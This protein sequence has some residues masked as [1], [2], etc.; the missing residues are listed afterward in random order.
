MRKAFEYAGIDTCAADGLCSI[1]CPVSIDTGNLMKEM[2]S[3]DHDSL[4]RGFTRW[5]QKHPRF[6][7][8]MIR[9]GLYLMTPIRRL[10]NHVG[11]HQLN[12]KL[13]TSSGGRIPL[14]NHLL[15]SEKQLNQRFLSRD[16]AD[17]VYFPSCISRIIHSGKALSVPEAFEYILFQAGLQPTYPHQVSD[18]CCGLKHQ[19]KGYPEVALQSAIATTQALWESS[20]EGQLPIVMD[21]SPCTS[22]LQNYDKI[23]SGIHLARWRSLKIVDI[24]EY[25]ND[26]VVERLDIRQK[27][28]ARVV[29]HP[30]CSNIKDGSDEILMSLAHKCAETVVQPASGA[31]CGFAGD[32]GLHFPELTENAAHTEALNVKALAGERHYSTSRMCE[33]GMSEATKRDYHSIVFLVHEVMTQQDS[34][35]KKS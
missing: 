17:L 21:T 8:G 28:K 22:H 10:S 7:L 30:T 25:L 11:F 9:W 34:F 33:I 14:W 29:L 27:S 2:R 6:H 12:R 13:T 3:R 4:S 15:K 32:R 18:L 16:A 1:A 24:V 35:E 31:C 5:T 19:S 26:E 20:E 23:L